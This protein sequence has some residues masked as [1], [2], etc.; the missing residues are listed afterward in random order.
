V[1]HAV[2]DRT[3]YDALVIRTAPAPQSTI[4]G[5]FLLLL[6]AVSA[7]APIPLALRS[8]GVLLSAY[9]AFSVGGMPWA[10]VIALL[11][12]PLGL[13]GG[14]DAWLVMLPIVM[15]GNLLAMLG[16]EYAW[17]WPA[18]VVSPLLLVAPQ[19]VTSMISERELFRVQ[20]PWEPDAGA[21]IALHALIAVAG[22][23]T[24]ILLERRRP[25]PA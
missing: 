5:V 9:L 22:V 25:Q 8:G 14:D 6:A 7:V 2:R 4:I 15:S 12:P 10:Y 23:L 17:R 19:I 20:L 21:W 3:G 16:L 13:L 18:L 11:V 24:A 1:R